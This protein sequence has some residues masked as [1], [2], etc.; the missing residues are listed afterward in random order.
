MQHILV[1]RYPTFALGD[2]STVQARNVV[3][4]TSSLLEAKAFRSVI[5]L[6]QM[7][8]AWLHHAALPVTNVCPSDKSTTH[9]IQGRYSDLFAS[10]QTELQSLASLQWASPASPEE[11]FFAIS[12]EIGCRKS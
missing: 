11:N 3:Q 4:K 7:M 1:I 12:G 8:I 5:H 9:V 2:T 6:L 10:V